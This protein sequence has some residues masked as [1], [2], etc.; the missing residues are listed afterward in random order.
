MDW[1]LPGTKA[2]G[3][4][5]SVYSLM[6]LLQHDFEFY[7]ITTNQDLGSRARYENITPDRF[8]TSG[9]IHYYYFSR[10]GLNPAQVLKVLQEVNPDLVY[11][12]SFWS[13][14]FSISLVR[15]KKNGLLPVPVL[16][17]PRGMLG[18]GALGLKAFKKRLF[19]FFARL[20]GLYKTLAFHASQQQEEKDIL[21]KFP[22]ARIYVAP[23][24]NAAGVVENKSVKTAGHLKLF[25]LSRIA[26]VKNLHM[27]LEL[28]QTIPA[29]Y[30]VSYDIF[31]N[32][33]SAEYWEECKQLIQ[34]LPA[35]ITVT[36]KG[37]LPFHTVQA[38]VCNYHA[39]FLP[40]LNENFGH[41]IVESLLCGCPA[42]IS[43]Q[44]PWNDLETNNA[45][46]AIALADRTKFKEAIIY[47]AQL[48]AAEFSQ[49]SKAAIEYIRNRINLQAVQQQYK[50]LFNDCIQN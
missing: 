48:N 12:N 34:K 5:R 33:E 6:N 31:G 8:F 13:F 11:L 32:I 22:D 35:N 27:A 9:N 15:F 42:I 29:E 4:V 25:F 3:P 43:D 21:S 47:M 24:V 44:T 28:L 18:K 2:G 1:Y 7:L 30:T 19:L 14:H 23:N 50:N 37:E 10:A 17:A 49:K 16:L 38:T 40:T 26:R 41:S 20:S 39:L 36:H 46:F 45:G